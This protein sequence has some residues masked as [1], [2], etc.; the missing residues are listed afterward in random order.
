MPS[1]AKVRKDCYLRNGGREISL[2]EDC[3]RRGG[4]APGRWHGSG[5][6]EQG[7]KGIVSAKGL[8]R[9]SM[10]NTRRRGRSWGVSFTRM[11][12]RP[13]I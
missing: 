12:W 1:T 11:G 2:G 4:S 8:V 9:L 5:A 7:L 13:G 6:V 10:G 3:H